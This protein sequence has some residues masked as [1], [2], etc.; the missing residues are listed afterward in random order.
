MAE[1][2]KRAKLKFPDARERNLV[3]LKIEP[4]V[5]VWKTEGGTDW[6]GVQYLEESTAISQLRVTIDHDPAYVG[7]DLTVT[8]PDPT[9][10]QRAAE[11]I[12]EGISEDLE[13]TEVPFVAWLYDNRIEKCINEETNIDPLVDHL[14]T[15]LAYLFRRRPAFAKAIFPVTEQGAPR[16]LTM[17][18]LLLNVIQALEKTT[19]QKWENLT[20][21]LM[22]PVS[23]I[24]MASK[25]PPG[26]KVQ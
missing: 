21:L 11:K 22:E 16:D 25:L 23:V 7:V 2:T 18:G 4:K 12:R 8:S 17:D 1:I 13:T 14:Q 20:R 6:D 19:G 3:L 5:Y 26:G 9:P 15:L 24:S 10:A